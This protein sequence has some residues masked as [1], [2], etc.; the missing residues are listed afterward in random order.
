MEADDIFCKLYPV[1]KKLGWVIAENAHAY[2]IYCVT[3]AN[4]GHA[5]VMPRQHVQVLAEL[6]PEAA[7]A[8]NQLEV[9]VFETLKRKHSENPEHLI[10]LYTEMSTNPKG[11]DPK[12][13]TAMLS[14]QHIRAE[15]L[16]RMHGTNLDKIAGRTVPHYHGNMFLRYGDDKLGIADAVR[17]YLR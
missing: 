10:P 11:F 8:F 13:A 15:P 12:F 16:G 17:E 9:D 7:Y 6:G 3:P 1:W 4:Q 5:L 14:H 2:S